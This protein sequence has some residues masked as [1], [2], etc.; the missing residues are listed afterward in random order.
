MSKRISRALISILMVVSIL[1]VGCGN[2]ILKLEAVDYHPEENKTEELETAKFTD[3]LKIPYY[4]DDSL[5]PYEAESLHNF[6][7]NTLV[8]DSLFTL[9]SQDNPI[10]LI[11]LSIDSLPDG[12]LVTIN[13]NQKFSDGQNI[14]YEDIVYSF[15]L[16]KNHKYYGPALKHVTNIEKQTDSTFKITLD[17]PDIYF[18]RCLTFPIIKPMADGL[19][20][21]SG[22]FIFNDDYTKL[23]PSRTS[24]RKVNRIK[25]IDLV[26]TVSEENLSFSLMDNGIDLMY[27]DLQSKV[28]IGVGIGYRQVPINNL[29]YLGAN[30]YILNN[31]LR[32]YISANIDRD[33]ISRN[34]FTGFAKPT[35]YPIK[36][37]N[38]DKNLYD[39][40]ELEQKLLNQGYKKDV[41]NQWIFGGNYVTINILVNKESSDKIVIGEYLQKLL[42]QM[43]FQSSL[44]KQDYKTYLYNINTENY[45]IYVGEMK[46]LH[47]N[48]LSSLLFNKY[49]KYSTFYP[50]LLESYITMKTIPESE[51]Q[52]KT[53]FTEEI[54]IIPIVFRRGILCY[55]RDFSANIVATEQD[56]FYN[57]EN[58]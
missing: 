4:S 32:K 36:T 28:N 47:N 21:G 38:Y 11:A 22:R 29:V 5:N 14:T 58:W 26:P 52:F 41:N 55:S 12:Y 24:I 53:T 17:E 13:T 27:S 16:A 33:A 6:V 30:P 43:G 19:P 49:E 40:Q 35:N 46:L 57:I 15:E 10:P 45:G 39:I 37:D 7:I 34:A 50:N 18:A 20:I 42:V 23:F 51:E 8:Y 56:I 2:T 48:D 54:P 25:Q 3:R 31:T 1:L 9:D 44:I